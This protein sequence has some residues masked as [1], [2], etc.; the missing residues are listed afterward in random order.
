ME[1]RLSA[2]LAVCLFDVFT[3]NFQPIPP[4]YGGSAADGKNCASFCARRGRL[5]DDH[6]YHISRK[7]KARM[8][9]T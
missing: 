2:C 6:R 8:L 5:I 3:L 9:S 4:T 1:L 7:M